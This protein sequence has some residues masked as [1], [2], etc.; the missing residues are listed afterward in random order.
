LLRCSS[1]PS[2]WICDRFINGERTALSVERQA[3]LKIFRGKGNCTACHVG[4]NFTDEQ[5]HN[6]G[7]AWRS[8]QLN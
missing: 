5:V 1:F 6:T 8:G 7:V 3:G 2:D 4:P